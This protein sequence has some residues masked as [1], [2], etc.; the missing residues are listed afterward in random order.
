[1][2]VG[3]GAALCCC[4]AYWNRQRHGG[5]AARLG[6]SGV[7]NVSPMTMS[8]TDAPAPGSW[9]CDLC[10]AEITKPEVGL[11]IWRESDNR[12]M[13]DFKIVHKEMAP[14]YCWQKA[15][16]VGYRASYELGWCLGIDGLST[17]LS[18]LSR[19]P[20]DGGG[21]PEVALED[22]DDYVDLVRR[23]QTPYYEQARRRFSDEDVRQ[24]LV[25]V[26]EEYPY[27]V[28]NL[29]WAAEQPQAGPACAG[30]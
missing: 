26:N 9:V 28:E 4:N 7:S 20:V 18:W 8:E 23:L 29:R 19:G 25:G 16:A 15:D 10:G 17:L 6:A 14:W 2:F 30:Q 12:P 5:V 22:L 13:Y 1:M 11:V 24:R 21:H 3:L 27:M